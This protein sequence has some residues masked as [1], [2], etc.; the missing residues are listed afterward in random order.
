MVGICTAQKAEIL[1]FSMGMTIIQL[2]D[3]AK[4]DWKCQNY[5]LAGNGQRILQCV[6]NNDPYALIDFEFS[7]YLEPQVIVRMLYQFSTSYADD[8]FSE[9]VKEQYKPARIEKY[10][11]ILTDGSE[12]F[13]DG[14]GWKPRS[15]RN[16]EGKMDDLT[17]PL[18]QGY[19]YAVLI[20]SDRR[21]RE[22][23]LAAGQAR[24]L[25]GPTP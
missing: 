9:Y 13:A 2:L 24:A 10:A 4:D 8:Q 15:R 7:E 23:D 11:M 21:L 25:K 12:L 16:A 3:Q 19:S 5:I 1:G 6:P 17:P 14:G 20:V 22:Q 18:P